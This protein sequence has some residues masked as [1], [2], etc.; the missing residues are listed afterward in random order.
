MQSK[1][2]APRQLPIIEALKQQL[3]PE[4]RYP[5]SVDVARQYLCEAHAIGLRLVAC[6]AC[7]FH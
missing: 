1:L 5:E 2:P 7:H 6:E 3:P 4:H